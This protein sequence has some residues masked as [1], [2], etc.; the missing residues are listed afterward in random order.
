MNKSDFDEWVR[1]LTDRGG[2]IL[3]E[4]L[5]DSTGC[6]KCG[7]DGEVYDG[8]SDDYYT[9]SE[10]NGTGQEPMDYDDFRISVERMLRREE[11]EI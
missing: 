11:D 6:S 9:C 2:E 8:G 10:C 3:N 5:S 4:M 7:G 1:G